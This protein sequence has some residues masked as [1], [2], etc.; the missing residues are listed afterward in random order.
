MAVWRCIQVEVT[1]VTDLIVISCDVVMSFPSIQELLGQ[2]SNQLYGYMM[3]H[4]LGHLSA[5]CASGVVSLADAA[6]LTVTPLPFFCHQI[7]SRTRMIESDIAFTWS[8]N[9]TGN[10]E[11]Q[12]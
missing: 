12:S 7:S 4:S 2:P 8:S 1:F 5:L 3:G 11:C 9:D 10:E 6:R